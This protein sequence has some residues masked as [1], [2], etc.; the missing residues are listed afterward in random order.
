MLCLCLLV[1]SGLSLGNDRVH[2]SQSQV[3][4]PQD[5]IASFQC[6]NGYKLEGSR[7]R[8]CQASS[9]GNQATPQCNKRK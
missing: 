2:Y 3:N 1:C 8:T 9:G 4:Y 7:S 5:T 6:N